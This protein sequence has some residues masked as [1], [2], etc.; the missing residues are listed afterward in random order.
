MM[1]SNAKAPN[2]TAKPTNSIAKKR[3]LHKNEYPTL[4]LPKLKTSGT[5]PQPCRQ[6]V[7]HPLST[8]KKDAVKPKQVKYSNIGVNTDLT[9]EDLQT[10]EEAFKQKTS[11]AR[12]RLPKFM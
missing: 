9:M 7:R 6:I 11:K 3:R 10:L 8:K 12:K 2:S 4:K 5:V 1:N